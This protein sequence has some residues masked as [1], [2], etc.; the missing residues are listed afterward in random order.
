MKDL[1]ETD[2]AIAAFLRVGDV[3]PEDADTRYFLGVLYSQEQKYGEAITAF[4]RA[5]VLNPLHASAEF[6][7]A[8]AY[9]RKGDADSSRVHLAKFQRIVEKRL[10][11]PVGAGYGEQ[12]RYSVVEFARFAA[13][14][15]PP[16]IT[17]KFVVLPISDTLKS[18][19]TSTIAG[20]S[21][22]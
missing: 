20:S 22:T 1:N 10:G 13:I 18:T 15:P 12:G 4:D 16:A 19:G 14:E 11:S 2:K 7:L 6:G 21:S 5:L 8:R 17:V 3:A 9:Q